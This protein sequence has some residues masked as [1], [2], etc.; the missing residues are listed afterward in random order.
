[1]KIK[2]VDPIQ[3]WNRDLEDSGYLWRDLKEAK[4]SGGALGAG[5]AIEKLILLAT[6][7]N[8]RIHEMSGLR[9]EIWSSK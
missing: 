4:L 7:K 5:E 8:L 9:I 3:V 6:F 1:M 2:F